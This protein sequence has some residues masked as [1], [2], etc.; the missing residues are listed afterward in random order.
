[1]GEVDE[2]RTFRSVSGGREDG[3]SV[4]GMGGMFEGKDMNPSGLWSSGTAVESFS[5]AGASSVCTLAT[6]VWG[7]PAFAVVCA[8]PFF[9][10]A[11]ANRRRVDFR[12]TWPG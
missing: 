3:P 7:W 12:V 5:E 10:L 6:C 2:S 8:A 4:S 11:C 9:F 1:M